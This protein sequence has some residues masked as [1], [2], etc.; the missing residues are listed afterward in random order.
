MNGRQRQ[1]AV[2]LQATTAVPDPRWNETSNCKTP[3]R[4]KIPVTLVDWGSK[5]IR[6]LVITTVHDA[7]IQFLCV[8]LGAA[9]L[10]PAFGE[11]KGGFDDEVFGGA[12]LMYLH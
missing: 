11:G 12:F 1:Q 4:I 10:P 5:L 3:I 6:R 9:Y 7:D 2:I 8:W